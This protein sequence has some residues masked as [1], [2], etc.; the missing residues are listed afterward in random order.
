ML[1]ERPLDTFRTAVNVEVTLWVVW[2]LSVLAAPIAQQSSHHECNFTV[3]ALPANQ[4][5]QTTSLAR[6]NEQRFD[7]ERPNTS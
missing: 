6:L 3:A 5:Q 7:F 1:V 2:L 4:S